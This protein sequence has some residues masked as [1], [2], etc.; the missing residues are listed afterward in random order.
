ME[1]H[2]SW[3]V[4][5]AEGAKVDKGQVVKT[6]REE[7]MKII[8][9]PFVLLMFPIAFLVVCFDVARDAVEQLV[10]DKLAE[11]K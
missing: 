1:R 5:Q 8:L 9:I 11:D 7:H 10:I 4:S 3:L 2:L 6:K